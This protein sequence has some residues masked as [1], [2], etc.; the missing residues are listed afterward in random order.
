MMFTSTVQNPLDTSYEKRKRKMISDQEEANQIHKIER[1]LRRLFLAP[2]ITVGLMAG[3]MTTLL[4][5]PLLVSAFSFSL[6][7][8]ALLDFG[9]SVLLGF[10]TGRLF[11]RLSKT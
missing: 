11:W 1:S 2:T 8:A 5:F 6:S 7:L 3:L 9:L 10:L 4:L